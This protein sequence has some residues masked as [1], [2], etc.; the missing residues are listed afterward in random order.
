MKTPK[1]PQKVFRIMVA[2]SIVLVIMLTAAAGVISY[3]IASGDDN[4]SSAESAEKNPQYSTSALILVQSSSS[5]SISNDMVSTNDITSS[6]LLANTCA[7]LFK[8]DPDMKSLISGA[9]VEITP[10][11]NSYFLKITA[12]SDDSHQAAN[13]AN[14]VAKT[15]PSVFKKYFGDAG[16]VSVA[17][18]A[19]V[20]SSPV[21][22]QSS[23]KGSADETNTLHIVLIASLA[24][25]S[26]SMLLAILLTAAA[27]SIQKKKYIKYL[28]TGA[29]PQPAA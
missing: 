29:A 16:K 2:V 20:P 11:E 10:V 14:L 25:L 9:E 24:A 18:E 1:T 4:G 3:L 22:A 7:T 26:A 13:V 23:E 15:A 5:N 27:V 6:V 8:V 28:Q 17:E 19:A 12:T 21:G